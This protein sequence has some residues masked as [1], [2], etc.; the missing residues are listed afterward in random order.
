MAELK[1]K[2][3][4]ENPRKYIESIEDPEQRDDSLKLLKLF[5]DVTKSKAKM[6]GSRIIGFGD[7]QYQSGKN[8][9]DWFLTGFASRKGQLTI[10]LMSGHAP[11]PAIMKRLG[12]HKTGGGC[13][14]IRKLEDIDTK[15]LKELVKTS[16][17]DFKKK[18]LADGKLIR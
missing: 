16:T 9:N 12:K 2:K 7:F 17:S 13:I 5:E 14:Y 1:T 15:V 8:L 3:T 4:D 10:Y 11:Y 6:W 18:K